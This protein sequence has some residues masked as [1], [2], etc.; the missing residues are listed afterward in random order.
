M[1][2]RIQIATHIATLFLLQ[3]FFV[4]KT[5]TLPGLRCQCLHFIKAVSPKLIKNFLIV[6]KSA[7]CTR[8]E[9]I[10]TVL[11]GNTESE[12]CLNP[13]LKQGKRLQKCWERI[14]NDPNRKKECIKKLRNSPKP[15]KR[16]GRKGGNSR[17][18]PQQL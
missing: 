9:I 12:T 2:F 8:I 1:N 15:N 6:P 3:H 18:R 10:L 11:Q 16:K 7:H 17:S 4:V 13:E 5:S 14:L